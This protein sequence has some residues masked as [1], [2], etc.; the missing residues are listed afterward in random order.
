MEYANKNVEKFDTL[1]RTL[2]I[3]SMYSET[4]N[5]STRLPEIKTTAE[6]IEKSRA[7]CDPITTRDPAIFFKDMRKEKKRNNRDSV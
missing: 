2:L 6:Y 7:T 4:R 5:N 3:I 1:M